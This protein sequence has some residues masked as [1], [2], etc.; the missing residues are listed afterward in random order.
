MATIL[1]LFKEQNK[2]IYGLAGKVY[3]ESKG[4]INPARAAALAVTSPNAV[5]DMVGNQVAG[6]IKG[7]ANRPTDTIFK[8]DKTFA[9]PISLTSGINPNNIEANTDYYVKTTTAPFANLDIKTA[10]SSPLSFV[11]NGAKE[12]L[13]NPGVTKNAVQTL[14][15]TLKKRRQDDNKGYGTKYQLADIGTKPMSATKIFSEH[16]PVYEKINLNPNRKKYNGD[17]VQTATKTRENKNTFDLVNYELLTN[18]YDKWEDFEKLNENLNIPYVMI[19]I[20]DSTDK[21]FLPGTISGLSEDFSP[22]WNGFKYV[23]SPFN[24]YRYG[25]VERS[26]KFELKLYYTD[27][28]TKKTMVNNL[29][30]IRKIVY[31]S[32][33]L[34]SINYPNNGGYSPV[35]FKPN[36]VYLTING[37]YQRLFGLIDSLSFSIDD[38]TPWPVTTDDMDMIKEKPHPAVINISFGFKVIEN[39]EI[40]EENGKKK[41]VYA[42]EGKIIK[43]KISAG[44][45]EKIGNV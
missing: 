38:N 43:G 34:I 7:S 39:P 5:A 20:Y 45:P 16:A 24:V 3:I 8:S 35:V 1:D 40:K 2:D 14:K 27:A 30:R 37:L 23:G 15:D 21:I 26:I 31:P 44:A 28:A 12:A 33:D 6:L 17:F 19:Q 25:G 36:L 32:E 41:L 9:K 29:N 4:V 13:R 42:F 22:E 18:S 10:I 11:A